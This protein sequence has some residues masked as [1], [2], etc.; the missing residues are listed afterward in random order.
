M[1]D[2]YINTVK[3][4]YIL[5]VLILTSH[6]NKCGPALQSLIHWNQQQFLKVR[7]EHKIFPI[8]IQIFGSKGF[9][10][11]FQAKKPEFVQW[12]GCAMKF[13]VFKE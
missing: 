9:N 1:D 7:L 13:K 8:Q 12:G 6:P 10:S 11:V 5:V 3:F 4:G 2:P